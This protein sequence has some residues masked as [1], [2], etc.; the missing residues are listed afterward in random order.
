MV[1]FEILYRK[2]LLQRE[3]KAVTHLKMAV[4]NSTGLGRDGG[5]SVT[6]ADGGS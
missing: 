1:F 2:D 4:W 5:E 6:Y 3:E